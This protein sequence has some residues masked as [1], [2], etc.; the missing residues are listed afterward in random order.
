MP[1]ECEELQAD[2]SEL[3][4]SYEKKLSKFNQIGDELLQLDRE[5]KLVEAWD[6]RTEQGKVFNELCKDG[7]RLV[8]QMI[9]LRDGGCSIL[10]L[11]KEE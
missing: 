6:L 3:L 9:N 11:K 10:K 5:K 7:V 8:G 2:I 4:E 1:D